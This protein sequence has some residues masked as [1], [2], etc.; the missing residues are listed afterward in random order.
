MVEGFL[1]GA[2]MLFV[3]VFS[4]ADVQLVE[5]VAERVRRQ[6]GFEARVTQPQRRLIRW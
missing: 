3:V 1:D 4:A 2:A 6:I 5:T